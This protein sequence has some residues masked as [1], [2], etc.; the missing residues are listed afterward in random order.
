M[1]VTKRKYGV[2]RPM[3]ARMGIAVVLEDEAQTFGQPRDGVI[4]AFL[5]ASATFVL[6]GD[7]FQ[8][9]GGKDTKQATELDHLPDL[10]K[11]KVGIRAELNLNTAFGPAFLYVFGAQAV[12]LYSSWLCDNAGTAGADIFVSETSAFDMQGGV[13]GFTTGTS[14]VYVDSTNAT[15]TNLTFAA[16]VGDAIFAEGLFNPA[17]V[18]VDN[19]LFMELYGDAANSLSVPVG[20]VSGVNSVGYNTTESGIGHAVFTPTGDPLL[21]GWDTPVVTDCST[22]NAWLQEASPLVDAG[23]PAIFDVDGTTSDIGAYGGPWAWLVDSDGDGFFEDRDCDDG[24]SA[25][26]TGATEVVGDG[27]D[28]DCDGVD[29][30]DGDGDGFR[31]Y[32]DCDDSDPA[33]NP[34]EPEIAY[35]GIDQ[36][37]DGA[38]LDD[39]DGDGFASDVV[40]GGDCD[41]TD[42]TINPGETDVWYD[43]VDSDCDGANDFDADGDGQ[44]GDG[45]PDCDDDDPNI[46]P[47]ATDIWYDGIDSDCDGANDYDADGDGHMSSD[48]TGDDCDDADP[49]RHPDATDTPYD[50]IDQDCSGEDLIDVDGDGVVGDD[51]GGSD[52]DDTDPTVF[53]GAQEDFSD[54]DRDCDGY[55]GPTGIVSPRECSSLGPPRALWV[56]LLLLPL[57]SR[58]QCRPER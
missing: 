49:E 28:Q 14:S 27:I 48:F 12:E 22:L 36:D 43:G 24:D 26:Y 25:I 23:N 13:V 50:G 34:G 46:H 53:P 35:D 33:I 42:P 47:G 18:G 56:F 52:C 9:V 37:C 40:G 31:Y 32:E 30:L 29:L 7:Q 20:D 8:P 54:V 21:Q 51:I 2:V 55:A 5:H 15:L 6:Q 4:S 11:R 17:T 38:D 58:R 57:I 16:T 39:L 45:G 19:T 1:D 41:D 10:Q 44:D 3:L